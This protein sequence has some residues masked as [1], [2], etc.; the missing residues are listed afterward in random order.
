M[1]KKLSLIL[2]VFVSLLLGGCGSDHATDD[3]NSKNDPV[4][5]DIKITPPAITIPKG[6]SLPLKATGYY[7][8]GTTAD[9]T[10]S[11]EWNV[12]DDGKD[13]IK[14]DKLLYNIVSVKGITSGD[15][16]ISARMNRTVSSEV[17][18][19]VTDAK[20]VQL[21]IK[22]ASVDADANIVFLNIPKTYEVLLH[23]IGKYDDGS[24]LDL[25]PYVTWK[26]DSPNVINF[27]KN[28]YSSYLVASGEEVGHTTMRAKFEEI[29]SFVS[30]DITGTELTNIRIEQLGSSN[31]EISVA[32]G[33]PAILAAVGTFQDGTSLIL[34]NKKLAWSI[35]D[36]AIAESYNWGR[37]FLLT[38]KTAGKTF[39]NVT[40][41]QIKDTRILT[42]TN[43][44]LEKLEITSGG[45]EVTSMSI[46]AGDETLLRV[47]AT[48]DDGTTRPVS[49]SSSLYVDN[50][51]AAYT[52]Q[53][54]DDYFEL[55]GVKAD[56]TTNLLATFG[57][58]STPTVRIEVEEREQEFSGI[59]IT[60]NE[61]MLF[62]DN[63]LYIQ[64]TAIGIKS[65]G[66][67]IDISD[68]VEWVSANPEI[69]DMQGDYLWPS[70]TN[71]GTTTVTAKAGD[72]VSINP[73]T[74]TVVLPKN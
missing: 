32:V 55:I 34:S 39:I 62:F 10:Q 29:S 42:V 9:I 30:V 56:S 4:L 24:N 67:R 47:R 63:T 26:S 6:A 61:V 33:N 70:S 71:F 69:V 60:P 68:R 59:E 28:L 16:V 27:D 19:K 15:A 49:F 5:E 17:D 53:P 2:C 8:D 50:P 74:V 36:Q 45:K 44:G 72:I 11:V 58:L 48:Y 57:G 37:Y 18:V 22:Q 23:A 41:D 21:E 25:T 64:P 38:G 35:D 31:H 7:S 43:A 12:N 46:T 13:I 51:D 65:N 66:T 14:E 54:V 52:R 40:R 1:Y 20:L 73:M 3:G